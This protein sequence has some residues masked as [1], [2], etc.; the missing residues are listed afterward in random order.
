[1]TA[2]S[3]LALVAPDWIS[4][5]E[6]IRRTGWTERWL[7]AKAASGEV[8]SR[9]A[10]RTSGR[11]QREYLLSSLPRTAAPSQPATILPMAPLGPLFSG[12]SAVSSYPVLLK[13]PE[14]QQQ[15]AERN[16]T[17]QPLIDFAADPRA[18][19]H[20][21]LP[22]GR[23]LDSQ[24]RLTEWIL[25]QRNDGLTART[26]QR[27]LARYRQGGFPALAD[28]I[29]RDKGQSRWFARNRKAA[30]L[31]AYLWLGDVDTRGDS[32]KL[33]GSRQSVS[34]IWQ[35]I[36]A[37]AE[38]LGL[39]P[40]DLPS[41][42]TVR[43]FLP[44]A[45]SPA[46]SALA[47][48][49]KRAYRERMAPYLIRGYTDVYANQIWV[50]DLM[51]HD[52]EVANDVFTDQP[53]GAPVR[54]VLSAFMDYRS[55]KIV[56]ASWAWF[57][58]SS[59]INATI[60][61]AVIDFGPPDLFYVDN[62]KDY[63]KVAKG[64]ASGFTFSRMGWEQ[65]APIE[66]TGFIARIGAGV[67]HCIPRHPQSKGIERFFRTEHTGYD[68]LGA[69]YTSGT[70]FTRPE[71]TEEAMSRHRWLMKRGRVAE[72]G[73]MP[74]STFILGCLQWISDYNNHPHTG[75]GMDGAS[76]NQVF[77]DNPNPNQKPAPDFTALALL[78]AEYKRCK[79][80][81]CGVRLN[82]RRYTPQPEDRQAWA[83]MHHLNE[84]EILVA[85]DA[86]DPEHAVACDLDGRPLAWLVA[87]AF[88]RFA[89][90]DADVQAEIG[91][92]MELRRGLEKA[93][94]LTIA[95]IAGEARAAGARNGE[96][97]LFSRLQLPSNTS[98]VITQR[99][100]RLRPNHNAVAPRTATQIAADILEDLK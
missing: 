99:K 56:G 82:K 28:R 35:Q 57:G 6:T 96:E 72:S 61:R 86:H 13:D 18:F 84:S 74:A 49:G 11:T 45:V 16:A 43:A 47:R 7:R 5:E 21:R 53:L 26:L 73:H 67:T 8:I 33:R 52:R 41:Y 92:S 31:A 88:T 10:P 77:A 63:K 51:I 19:L 98:P 66:E 70:P 58:G 48:E 3:Q 40:N 97:M 87:Q 36:R 90:N 30:L 12:I 29:R 9:E 15:A 85:Y 55:R 1:M 46:I 37:Q 25:E 2:L 24:A 100:P 83:S 17:I 94:R 68:S 80:D 81:S 60:L 75:E 44:Q 79:V 20:L 64:A 54:V 23:P 91:Q 22:D 32:V 76:P 78:M 14:A 71:A 59:A 38:T 69:N 95:A 39:D 27:W 93:T 89:P 62:G 34:V 50:G 65:I 4:A 42:E